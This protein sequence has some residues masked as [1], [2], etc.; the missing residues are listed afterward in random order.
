MKPIKRKLRLHAQ[1][2]RNL[3]PGELERLGTGATS[4]TPTMCSTVDDTNC[5]DTGTCP[6]LNGS[7]VTGCCDPH[8]ANCSNFC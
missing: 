8:T 2:L 4:K 5:V 6:T 7:C 3:T 1:T